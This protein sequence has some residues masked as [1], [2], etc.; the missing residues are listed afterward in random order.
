MKNQAV[1]ISRQLMPFDPFVSFC[2]AHDAHALWVLVLDGWSSISGHA[3]VM[4]RG[5][6]LWCLAGSITRLSTTKERYQKE[7]FGAG[8][9]GDLDKG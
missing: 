2:M 3:L 6:S 4:P 5:V 7:T 8:T 1:G 9:P